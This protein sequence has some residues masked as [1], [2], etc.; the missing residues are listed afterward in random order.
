MIPCDAAFRKGDELGWFQHGSTII[1]FAPPGVEHCPGVEPGRVIR[2]GQPL[3]RMKGP[4]PGLAR[5]LA[6]NIAPNLTWNLT[7]N[8]A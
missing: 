7:P 3:L 4:D 5:G 1:V 8:L 6:P 2:V